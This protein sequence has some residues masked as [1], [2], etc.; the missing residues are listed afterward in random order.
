MYLREYIFKRGGVEAMLQLVNLRFISFCK[1]SVVLI[2]FVLNIFGSLQWVFLQVK[3]WR[4]DE[5]LEGKSKAVKEGKKAVVYW[6]EVLRLFSTFRPKGTTTAVVLIVKGNYGEE[7]SHVSAKKI[8]RIFFVH[9]WNSVK[10]CKNLRLT[11]KWQA[12]FWLNELLVT[13]PLP[14]PPPSTQLS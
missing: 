8:V 1:W 7:S 11:T 4:K 3:L 9:P 5:W 13:S 14:P 12:F 10:R 6:G 2:V